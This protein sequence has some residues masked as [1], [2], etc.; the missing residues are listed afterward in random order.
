MEFIQK[1]WSGGN[2]L[3]VSFLAYLVVFSIGVYLIDGW[4]EYVYPITSPGQVSQVAFICVFIVFAAVYLWQII[5]L[6]RSANNYS[7][8]TKKALWSGLAKIFLM[9]GV[10]ST[11]TQMYNS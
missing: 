9:L 2:S 3:A 10:L 11:L 4:L 6:W 5:G 7:K 1:H 8:T